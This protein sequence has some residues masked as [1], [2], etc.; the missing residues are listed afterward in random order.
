MQKSQA[1]HEVIRELRQQGYRVFVN[2][3]RDFNIK[4]FDF[5]KQTFELEEKPSP[6]G[7]CTEVNI[8]VPDPCDPMRLPGIPVVGAE[9]VCSSKDNYHRKRGVKI[10]LGRAL[11]MLERK[12]Q[13]EEEQERVATLEQNLLDAFSQGVVPVV[14]Q[15]GD[16]LVVPGRGVEV[17]SSGGAAASS[18]VEA[19]SK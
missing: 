1:N 3:H 18:N 6:C 13:L 12:R 5:E 8:Y 9:A 16:Q 19:E 15:E 10:A 14:E 2:H 7:G 17:E 11:V 4:S